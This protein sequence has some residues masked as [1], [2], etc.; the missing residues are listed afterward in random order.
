MADS[1]WARDRDYSGG[2]LTF[3]CS[4]PMLAKPN[5]SS[6]SL[7]IRMDK[8]GCEQGGKRGMRCK[9]R[10]RMGH[11]ILYIAGHGHLRSWFHFSVL[12]AIK[13]F[14]LDDDDDDDDG[15]YDGDYDYD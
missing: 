10:E 8:E 2:S 9:S 11:I 12:W 5:G 15:D 7:K 13:A 6:I 4:R 14:A 3:G 1:A